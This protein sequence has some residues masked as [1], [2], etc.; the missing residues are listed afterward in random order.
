MEPKDQSVLIVED[1]ADLLEILFTELNRE[2]FEV[3]TARD[4]IEG[5]RVALEER[6][7]LIL[8]D[9]VMPKKDGLAMLRELR[10]D[11]WGKGAAV[12]LLSNLD[13]SE[14]I[15]G[16]LHKGALDYI[17]KSRFHTKDIVKKVKERLMCQ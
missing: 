6:P 2:G 13:D 11:S 1:E 12:I 17:V 10:E 16:A 9:I 15:T 8:L 4:G 7:D 3:L 14:S 5:L